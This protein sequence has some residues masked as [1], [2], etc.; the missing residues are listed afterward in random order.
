LVPAAAS[1]GPEQTKQSP[2]APESPNL[3]ARSLVVSDL[4]S[5]TTPPPLPLNPEPAVEETKR[6]PE[7]PPDPTRLVLSEHERGDIKRFQPLFVTPRAVK[8]FANTYSLIRV[9]VGEKE[10]SDYVGAREA[11]GIYRVPMLLLAVTSAFPSLAQPWLRWLREAP[12]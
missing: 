10:W 11:P 9:A 3:D 2:P 5:V 4:E 1:P 8:R 7:E 12:T 6:I